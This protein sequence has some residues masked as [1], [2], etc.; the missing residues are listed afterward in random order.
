M[1]NNFTLTSSKSLQVH[2]LPGGR[3]EMVTGMT[4]GWCCVYF[5]C[6]YLILLCF[7]LLLVDYFLYQILL[8]K[9]I[10]LTD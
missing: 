2:A 8:D 4:V 7:L 1:T 5:I 9:M 6:F 10:V 3:R